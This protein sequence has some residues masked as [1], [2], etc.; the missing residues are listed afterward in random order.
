MD[1]TPYTYLD[2]CHTLNLFCTPPPQPSDL[3]LDHVN[4]LPQNR[5]RAPCPTTRSVTSILTPGSSIPP[6]P[7]SLVQKIESGAFIE[8]ADLVP[9]HLGFKETVGSKSKQR[10]VTNI[11]EWLQAF[12]VCV[13]HQQKATPTCTRLD[14]LPDSYVG[15]Q[16]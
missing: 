11:S 4:I 15:S 12:A 14:G 5:R 2:Y 3:D 10:P 6:V 16:Q 9:N 13:H 1:A 7:P 8:L